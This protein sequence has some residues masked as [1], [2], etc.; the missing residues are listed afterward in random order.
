[1]INRQTTEDEAE[2]QELCQSYTRCTHFT[3]MEADFP[4]RSGE[5]DLQCYLWKKCIS[6]IPCSSMDCSSSVAGP[7]K[8]SM[9][10]ACCSKFQPGVCDSPAIQTLPPMDEGEC[11]RR[12]RTEKDC[13]FY[14]TSPNACILHSSCSPERKP[15]RGCR[16][17]A[18]RPPINKLPS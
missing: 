5:P 9:P 13:L 17:G 8:P 2:C 1:M 11:Q 4:L 7:A 10:S 6:K 18:K 14:S 16:S 3:F 12:C 15:C